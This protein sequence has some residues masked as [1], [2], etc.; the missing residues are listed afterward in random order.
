M[1]AQFQ[2]IKKQ[3]VRLIHFPCFPMKQLFSFQFKRGTIN[4]TIGFPLTRDTGTK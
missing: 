3:L 1:M 4:I 2:V